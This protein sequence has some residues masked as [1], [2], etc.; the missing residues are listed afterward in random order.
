MIRAASLGNLADM[1][2]SPGAWSSRRKRYDLDAREDFAMWAWLEERDLL[3]PPGKLP[4][5]DALNAWAEWRMREVIRSHKVCAECGC[6]LPRSAFHRNGIGRRER[7]TSACKSC[8]LK[9]WRRNR[10]RRMSNPEVR[11]RYNAAR[12]AKYAAKK[13]GERE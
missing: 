2:D 11:E 9:R 3:P 6:D 13:G 1:S 8:S 7:L 4:R 5:R 10:A 12:R